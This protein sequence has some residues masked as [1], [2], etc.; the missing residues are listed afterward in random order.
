MG[1]LL[2]QHALIGELLGGLEPVRIIHVHVGHA[3][4]HAMRA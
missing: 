1:S 2:E 4:T 3:S